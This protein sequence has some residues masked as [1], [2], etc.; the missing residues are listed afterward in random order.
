MHGW[1][2]HRT[3][4]AGSRV[5]TVQFAALTLLSLCVCQQVTAQQADSSRRESLSDA[6]WTGP[7][8]TAS[9]GT[10]PPGHVLLEPYLYDVVA[11]Q[12][13]GVGSR[14]YL[15]VGVTKRIGL[16]LIPTFGYTAVSH[17]ASS[18]GIG[19]GDI[20]LLSQYRFT[21]FET[22]RALPTMSVV[23]EETLPTGRYDQLGDRPSNGFGAGAFTTT[24]ALYS[25][26]YLWMPTGRILRLRLDLSQSLSGHVPVDGVSV[27][28]TADGF[29]G[30]AQP[31][32]SFT[33]S[34]GAEYSLTQRW[35]L[36]GDIAY[37]RNATTTVDGSTSSDAG[38][39]IT[40]L[41]SG[42][43]A[44]IAF[45]PAIEYNAGPGF[46]VIF[47]VRMIPSGRN[48]TGTVTPAVAVNIVR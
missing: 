14:T 5:R 19:V 12:M 6:W 22:G 25:Q 7:L 48:V 35:V 20:T 38:T 16:G 27:Y 21:Q 40:Q 45:A 23:L 11:P 10:L 32:A 44:P 28:G 1:R 34:T 42:T 31:G 17:G 33:A 30:E 13:N 29:S 2:D 41:A 39:M 3:T 43:S 9:A 36:A 8:L 46:G 26:T 47:G 4:S 24:I 15:I 37:S 18:S